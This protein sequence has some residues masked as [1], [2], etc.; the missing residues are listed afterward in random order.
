MA[1]QKQKRVFGRRSRTRE[2]L[3]LWVNQ[4]LVGVGLLIAILLLGTAVW[5]GTR[6]PALQITDIQV[7][8]GETI[9][10]D[11]IRGVAETVLDES[12]LRLI[13]KRFGWLYP[14]ATIRQRI[15]TIERVR[16]VTVGRDGQTV[17]ITFSEYLPAALW[18]D[19]QLTECVFIDAEGYAFTNAPHLSGE[20]FMRY[21]HHSESPQTG[22]Q[23]FS[24]SFMTRTQR[25]A[26]LLA[27]N[28]GWYATRVVQG[29]RA[30]VTYELAGGG[31]IKT[32]YD[33]ATE[34][35]LENLQTIIGSEDFA[36]LAPGNFQYIDLRF[37]N[38]VYVNEELPSVATSTATTTAANST[39]S[40]A[41]TAD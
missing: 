1:A 8:G 30:D 37:G 5:Y 2:P 4:T 39:T 11:E 34:E 15:Q 28:F 17:A 9:P 25:F 26:D 27:A 3:P 20:A 7:E 19:P 12:Y 31:A 14:A 41:E 21:I 35:T 23:A 22:Q 13:P 18:C 38:K 40:D 6:I 16:E 29:E 33:Y 32:T 24:P 36:D 10:R